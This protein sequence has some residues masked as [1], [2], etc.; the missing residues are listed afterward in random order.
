MNKSIEYNLLGCAIASYFVVSILVSFTPFSYQTTI[1][2]SIIAL[3]FPLLSRKN[4]LFLCGLSPSGALLVYPRLYLFLLPFAE[5]AYHLNFWV[6]EN[7][8]NWFRNLV[9]PGQFTHIFLILNIIFW[10]IEPIIFYRA[11][12]RLGLY[13]K[14]PF[15]QSSIAKAT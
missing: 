9:T 8:S 3:F 12:I 2:A 7:K 5:T 13:D 6:N 4:I 10:A 14:L 15:M 11:Y 1:V